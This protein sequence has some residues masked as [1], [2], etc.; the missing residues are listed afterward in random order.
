MFLVPTLRVGTREDLALNDLRTFEQIQAGD[1]ELAGGKGLSLARM[2]VTGLP[3]PPGFC[4]TT[5]AYRRLGGQ[6]PTNDPFL[7]EQIRAAYRQLG[8]GRVAV[9]SSATSEDGT[10]ASFAGQ[11]ETL[12]GVQGETEVCAAVARCWQ[13]LHSEHA[14]AYRRDRGIRAEEMAMAV[15][16][17][18]LIAAEVAGVLFTRDPFDPQGQRM[19]VEASWGLGESVVSGKVAPDRYYLERETGRV[20]EQHIAAKMVQMTTEGTQPVPAD[21]EKQPCLDAARLAELA[22][23][24]RRVEALFGEPCDVEWAWAESRFWLLQARPITAAGAAEREQVRREEIAALAA[25]SA[26]GGTV[27]SRY[28]IPEG[29]PEPTPMTWALVRH[30]LSGN[31]GYGLMYR[32]LGY[33]SS[34]AGAEECIYDLVAGRVYC[35]LSREVRRHAGALLYD[36]DFAA[37]KADPRKALT[38][39]PVRDP[40]RAGAL[41]WLL[42]PLRL[43]FHILGSLRRMVRLSRLSNSFA[44]HFRQEIL[45]AFAAETMR[46]ANEEWSNLPS[47]LLLERFH[48]WCKRTLE[49]YAR[50]SLKATALA[51]VARSGL[52]FALRRRFGAEQARRALGSLSMGVRPEPEADLPRALRDVIEGRLD[53]TAFLE[54]FGHRGNQEMELAQPR[55]S[56]DPAALDRLLRHPPQSAKT[57][58]DFAA[59]TL[60]ILAAGLKLPALERTALEMQVSLLRTYLSLRETAK[61]FFMLGYAL[62]RRALV[63]L[64]KRHHLQGGIFFLTP[65][66][67]PD[68]LASQ[69]MTKRIAERRRRRSL[70][71]SLEVPA[72]IFSD[73]LE[74][75]GRPQAVEGADQLQGVPLSSGVAEAPALVLDEPST[76]NL[77]SEPFILVCP[78]TDPAWVPLFVQA[79]GLVME[80]GGVLSHGAIVA[81]EYGLPAVAGV[82]NVQRRLRTGQRLRV[83]GGSGTVTVLP[84]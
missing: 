52:E 48:Y 57:A 63:E 60:E 44:A 70:A 80:I 78:S 19:L 74:V 84:D 41:F 47:P 16:V 28:N 26:P 20:V 79:R 30:L 81:R 71:L 37:L 56:D 65:E 40:S 59:D 17:Q 76:E 61:H 73:D 32:D 2:F 68:L 15:V 7:L 55:W 51:A 36:Y 9:R 53:R 54:R 66:E 33:G 23:L 29:M 21:K 50:A 13:S 22:E 25:L 75:I 11:M 14:V 42:L 49:E 82:P 67:L 18:R 3:V 46:A 5:A 38:P 8:G 24:G 1:A 10:V 34:T 6:C 35:N 27:W 62:I 69:D 12:L 77:P 58:E 43:P 39:Q 83:D 31:G 64:D 72:V 4:V 45:P